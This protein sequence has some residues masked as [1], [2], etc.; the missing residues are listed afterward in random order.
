MDLLTAV[1]LVNT[2]T[3]GVEGLRNNTEFSALWDQ[4]VEETPNPQSK[5]R[6]PKKIYKITWLNN[7]RERELT[8]TTSTQS[9]NN[10]DCFIAVLM[11]CVEKCTL[12]ESLASPESQKF[13]DTDKVMPLLELAL[14]S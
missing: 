13:L 2:A 6:Q 7:L 3:K 12:M 14:N 10:G 1:Q 8:R 5:K 4:C 11:Q 9:Q